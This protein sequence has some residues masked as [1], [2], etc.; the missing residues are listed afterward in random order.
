MKN[1]FTLFFALFASF[2]LSAQSIF[3]NEIHYDNIDSD[4]LEAIEIAGIPGTDLAGWS[5]ALYNG[6]SGSL[7]NTINL[8]GT[9]SN[10]G[11]GLGAIAF[12]I[13]VNGLQNGSPDGLALV[14]NLANVI[15][16]LSYEGNLTAA[17]GPAEGLTSTDIG[18]EE[19]GETPVG[20]S[21]QLTGNGIGSTYDD[22]T[23]TGPLASTLGSLNVGQPS[24]LAIN[25]REQLQFSVYPNPVTNGTINIVTSSNEAMQ[26]SVF[27]VLGK[28][29][30][31]QNV[32]NKI[33]V[34]DAIIPS[35][36]YILRL[37]NGVETSS[38]RISK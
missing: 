31:T 25:E 5:V 13:P 26:A 10:E 4:T 29:V 30:M 14:D 34:L 33:L 21:L 9:I 23:W 11:A 18:V 6:A 37:S 8:S 32:T 36:S 2:S 12:S 7:Y 3:I 17:N 38:V 1:N 15:Q 35:G 24:F 20:H 28:L 22:F 19:T 16:F 27:D